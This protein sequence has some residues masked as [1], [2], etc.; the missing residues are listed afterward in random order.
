MIRAG[1]VLIVFSVLVICAVTNT[2]VA[3]RAPA[4]QYAAVAEERT[5]VNWFLGIGISNYD[6]NRVWKDLRNAKTDMEI[7]YSTLESNYQFKS[8]RS[9]LLIDSQATRKNILDTLAFL[10]RRL[11]DSD[12]LIIYFAGHGYYSESTN[13]GFWV[14]SDGGASTSSFISCLELR[15][16]GIV[17]SSALHIVLFIDACY[18][19]GIFEDRKPKA[20]ATTVVVEDRSQDSTVVIKEDHFNT[21]GFTPDQEL[22]ASMLDAVSVIPSREAFVSGRLTPVTD[23]F[24]SHSPFALY[25]YEFLSADRIEPFTVS[26]IAEYVK[27][28]VYEETD[29]LPRYGHLREV[30]DEGGE[31]VFHPRYW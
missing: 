17:T 1:I 15:S 8:N 28:K 18:S 11:R 6:S 31:F 29:Q 22:K 3:L 27:P 2:A 13:I 14:P 16:K 4:L 9:I 7:I 30:G 21:R 19:S 10:S 24:G 26:N 25:L 20:P 5:Q 12:N 23:G